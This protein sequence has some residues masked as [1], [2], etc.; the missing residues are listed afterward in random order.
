MAAVRGPPRVFAA[1]MDLG[2]YIMA[3]KLCGPM[4]ARLALVFHLTSWFNAFTLMRTYST[5]LEA[6]LNLAAALTWTRNRSAAMILAGLS[7]SFRPLAAVFW[8]IFAISSISDRTFIVTTLFVTIPLILGC[9]IALDSWAYERWTFVPYNF[10]KFNL[11]DNM[12]GLYGTHHRFWYLTEGVTVTLM[13]FL[14]FTLLEMYHMVRNHRTLTSTNDRT[15]ALFAVAAVLYTSVLSMAAHK[16]HRFLLAHHWVFVLLAAKCFAR[17]TAS[18]SPE[19][20]ERGSILMA[21]VVGTQVL[22]AVFFCGIHQQA[23]DQVAAILRTHD[24]SVFFLTPCHQFAFH[25]HRHY[26]TTMG[27]LDCSPPLDARTANQTT[28]AKRFFD[29]PTETARI[30]FEQGKLLDSQTEDGLC[31]PQRVTGVPYPYGTL[32]DVLVISQSVITKHADFERWLAESSYRLTHRVFHAFFS[33]GPYDLET[34]CYYEIWDRLSME[35]IQ[36]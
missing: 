36:Q 16:E 14:P 33:E 9:N 30:L 35:N 10:V 25:S 6:M 34:P 21:V 15:V 22:A 31:L 29:E 1:F 8:L 24:R 3:E 7:V 32:P 19:H 4:V 5:S 12:S 2:M 13:T 26:N 20:R 23:G 28:W 27:F 11:L 17:L 18:R